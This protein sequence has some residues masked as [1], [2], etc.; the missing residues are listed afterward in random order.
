MIHTFKNDLLFGYDKLI[1]SQSNILFREIN[2]EN[3]YEENID[4]DGGDIVINYMQFHDGFTIFAVIPELM[5]FIQEF[6]LTF[7]ND[8]FDIKSLE[9]LFVYLE[10]YIKRYPRWLYREDEAL[11]KYMVYYGLEDRQMID[12]SKIQSSTVQITADSPYLNITDEYKELSPD[13][14]Y[15]GTLIGHEIVSITGTNGMDNEVVDIG[16]ETHKD[17]RHKGY[18]V[19]NIVALSDYLLRIG[20]VV[21]YSCNNLNTFSIQAALSSGFHIV[22]KEKSIWCP[23]NRRNMYEV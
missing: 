21:K 18:A 15:F 10:T 20:R 8:F 16:V 19:S 17:Y 2:R 6:A 3:G 5:D 1:T 4:K 13:G 23:L 7:S 22:A 9:Y 12:Y 14:V 11:E